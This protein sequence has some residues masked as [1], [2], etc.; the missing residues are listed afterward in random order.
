MINVWIFRTNIHFGS[1][2]FVCVTRKKVAEMKFVQKTRTF[3]VDEI[4]AY[5][6]KTMTIKMLVTVE[7]SPFARIWQYRQTWV[8][9]HLQITTTCIQ[10]QRFWGPNFNFCNI[11]LPLNNDHLST[12]AT[13]FGP[14]GGRCTQVWLYIKQIMLVPIMFFITEYNSKS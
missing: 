9:D 11:T 3:Y 12:T 4:D 1:F 7:K 5:R 2:Y 14:E 13:N 10:R 6:Y 8:N